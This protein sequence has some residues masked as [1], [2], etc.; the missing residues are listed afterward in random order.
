MSMK[1]GFCIIIG[2]CIDM[3]QDEIT[4][5]SG[6]SLRKVTALIKPSAEAV[7]IECEVWGETALRFAADEPILQ[8]LVVKG[9]LVGREWQSNDGETRRRT[10]IRIREWENLNEEDSVTSEA[11]EQ[12]PF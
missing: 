7:P 5:R 2:K 9:S 1:E 4:T 12:V 8:V 6:E 11:K 10:S 3:T